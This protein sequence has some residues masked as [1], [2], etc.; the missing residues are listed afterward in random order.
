VLSFAD[1][2]TML[3]ADKWWWWWWWWAASSFI[4]IPLGFI[5]L[6]LLSNSLWT[7]DSLSTVGLHMVSTWFNWYSGHVYGGITPSSIPRMLTSPESEDNSSFLRCGTV[8][9]FPGL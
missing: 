6:P 7:H 5:R 9:L 2:C 8:H 3:Y 1:S 4:L